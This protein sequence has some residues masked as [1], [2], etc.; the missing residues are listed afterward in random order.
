MLKAK[1][2]LEAEIAALLRKAELLDAQEVQC[3]GKGKRGDELPR[4]L[5]RRQGPHPGALQAQS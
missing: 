2:E 5:Q 4:G 3:F 1:A